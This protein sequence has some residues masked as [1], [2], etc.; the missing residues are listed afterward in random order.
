MSVRQQTPDCRS[1]VG[2]AIFL[3]WRNTIVVKVGL[4]TLCAI[5]ILATPSFT[6]TVGQPIAGSGALVGGLAGAAFGGAS[7]PWVAPG[8]ASATGSPAK[9]AQSKSARKRVAF[10]MQG[11]T[12]ST[13]METITL[14]DG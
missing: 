14:L 2:F 9:V 8:S 4:K 10:N 6:E 12:R 13:M 3:Y 1:G 7:S 5:L 11:Q